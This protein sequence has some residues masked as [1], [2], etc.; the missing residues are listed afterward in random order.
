M[1]GEDECN[2][3][4]KATL[5]DIR[6]AQ[7]DLSTLGAVQSAHII[8]ATRV[9]YKAH[10]AEGTICAYICVVMWRSSLFAQVTIAAI[11]LS[12]SV[13]TETLYDEILF[14]LRQPQHYQHD[15]V[16]L[17]T[18]MGRCKDQSQSWTMCAC[19]VQKWADHP[20]YIKTHA[21]L[22]LRRTSIVVH[23]ANIQL[24]PHP[25]TDASIAADAAQAL[26]IAT[27]T[28]TVCDSIA[29]PLFCLPSRGRHLHSS[30]T[31]KPLT[32]QQT[33]ANGKPS[34]TS[35]P[36]PGA[37][38]AS[39]SAATLPNPKAPLPSDLKDHLVIAL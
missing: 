11:T 4:S 20:L 10:A 6:E 2:D 25:F 35:P 3:H 18:V 9:V 21:A 30:T 34:A 26:Q 19:Y 24:A 13:P 15:V 32:L 5:R 7:P 17:P 16:V 27:G 1:V 33:S 8:R 14:G 23:V 37:P 12:S 38:T 29:T 39:P 22:V 28:H 31:T 36:A